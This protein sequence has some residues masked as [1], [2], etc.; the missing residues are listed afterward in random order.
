MITTELGNASILA[1]L[2]STTRVESIVMLSTGHN[3]LRNFN[4]ISKHKRSI[5]EDRRVPDHIETHP[6]LQN[7]T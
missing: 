6:S 7:P 4:E 2:V 1:V 3:A 5:P